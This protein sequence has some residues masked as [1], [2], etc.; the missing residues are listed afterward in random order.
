MWANH[1]VKQNYWNVHKYQ[2]IDT[3][4]RDSEVALE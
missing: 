4:L 1:E 2:E 3:R